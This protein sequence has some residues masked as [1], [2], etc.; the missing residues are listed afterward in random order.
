MTPRRDPQAQMIALRWTLAS[1]AVVVALGGLV[2]VAY[3]IALARVP[4]YR[5]SLERLVRARTGLDVRFHELALSWGWYGPEAVFRPVELGEPGRSRVLLRASELIVDF[6]AWHALHTG[7][8]E[9]GRVTLVAPDIDITRFQARGTGVRSGPPSESARNGDLD[10]LARWPRGRVDVEDA[11]VTVPDPA[12]PSQ[13]LQFVVRRATLS[14]SGASWSADAQAMLPQRLGR[15]VRIAWRLS[16][17]GRARASSATLRLDGRELQLGAW[18]ELLAASWLGVPYV[19]VAGIGNVTLLLAFAQGRLSR[20]SA[21]VHADDVTLES[22]PAARV[23]LELPLG[24]VRAVFRLERAAGRWQLTADRGAVGPFQLSALHAAWLDGASPAAAVDS[25]QLEGRAAGRIEDVVAWL[26]GAPAFG[27]TPVARNLRARGHAEFRFERLAASRPD[28]LRVSTVLAADSVLVAPQLP[29]FE[30][31]SGTLTFVGGH[32]LRTTL[33]ARWLGGATTVHLAERDRGTPVVLAQAEGM[34]DAQALVAATGI[35][36]GGVRVA[37]RTPWRGELVVDPAQDAWH[38]RLQASFVGVASTLPDPLAKPERQAAPFQIEISG[39]SGRALARVVGEN[40]RGTFE[41]VAREDG[42]WLP[43]RGV[44]RFGGG[45]AELGPRQDLQLEGRLDSVDLPA[46]LVAWRMLAATRQAPPVRANLEI[47][48]LALAGERYESVTLTARTRD[49]LDLR[50]DSSDLAGTVHW[51][52][53]VTRRS[54]IAAHLEHVDLRDSPGPTELGALFAALGSA[55][56]VQADEVT[57]HGHAF[58]TLVA[59]V[60]T[61]AGGVVVDPVHLSGETQDVEAAVRCS[62]AG[63]CRAQFELASRDA[64]ASLRAFGFRGDVTSR[65]A[66]FKGEVQWSRDLPALE[67]AWLASATGHLT[68]TLTDGT[69]RTA[70]EDSGV[71][72]ALLGVAALLSDSPA[73]LGVASPG[74]AAPALAFSRLSADY[75]LRDGT[76]STSDLRFEG[77]A[78]ILL[79]GQIGLTTRDYDCRV[80]ILRGAERLPQALRTFLSAPR[81]AAAWMAVRDLIS[82][83]GDTGAELHLGGTW[84]APDV[85]VVTKSDSNP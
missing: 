43:E 2:L 32:L 27:L 73:R 11:T 81:L 38:A 80:R 5:V 47:G 85:R 50:L 4:Q 34:L 66:V 1:L 63:A 62:S 23:P 6:D 53:E 31:V 44:L 59:H 14:R 74:A 69:V 68:V 41:L 48:E 26:D 3:R 9:A 76:L 70:P 60:E 82:G 40:V 84:E 10:L 78:E 22:A 37:G 83:P 51:P 57:W 18:R 39:S 42:S 58:G 30:H 20:A 8:L 77:D 36:T 46:W 67:Q 13:T 54:P 33:E 49:G 56:D 61:R 24:R 55:A 65:R 72:F 29:P 15:T 79:D 35:D 52:T 12:A 64:A 25:V 75:A 19:P 71:P 16:D 28:A 45:A 21:E 7:Q 17:T